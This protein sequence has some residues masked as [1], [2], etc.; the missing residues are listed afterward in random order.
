MATGA[1]K[2][3]AWA[4][5]RAAAAAAS[6]KQELTEQLAALALSMMVDSPAVAAAPPWGPTQRQETA[7]QAT[8]QEAQQETPASR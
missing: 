2:G 1:A 5:P 3:I 8:R 6:E 4:S 7:D